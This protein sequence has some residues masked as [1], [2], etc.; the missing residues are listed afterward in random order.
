MNGFFKCMAVLVFLSLVS[1]VSYADEREIPQVEA[2]FV[3][4]TP[5]AGSALSP[6]YDLEK[7]RPHGFFSL[8]I[9]LSAGDQIDKIQIE[10]SNGD[11]TFSIARVSVEGVFSTDVFVNF[12]TTSG[13]GSD[14]VDVIQLGI[15][16]C[17]KVRFRLFSAG[18]ST[19]T[20]NVVIQ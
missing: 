13:P 2:A 7:L 3:A 8:Q 12:T 4:A 10:V 14:G 17:R 19:V 20:A 6:V 11:S 16:I 5:V 18:T 15:P 9:N 1:F